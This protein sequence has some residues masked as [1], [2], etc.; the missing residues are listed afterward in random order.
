MRVVVASWMRARES[1]SP[2]GPFMHEVQ[3]R[4][5]G[6]VQAGKMY[7]VLSLAFH[8]QLPGTIDPRVRAKPVKTDAGRR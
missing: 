3:S 8:S 1:E 2:F 7:P 4:P 6:A 5:T